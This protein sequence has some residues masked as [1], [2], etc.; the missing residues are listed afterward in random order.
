MGSIS[1]KLSDLNPEA[2][3]RVLC[4][5]AEGLHNRVRELQMELEQHKTGRIDTYGVSEMRNDDRLRNRLVADLVLTENG[6]PIH[7]QQ[8]MEWLNVTL[9]ETEQK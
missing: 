4:A 1:T 7:D 9:R 6:I 8:S 2:Q 3:V 5:L